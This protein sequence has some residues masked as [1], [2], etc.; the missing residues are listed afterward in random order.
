MVKVNIFCRS[1][2]LSSCVLFWCVSKRHRSICGIKFHLQFCFVCRPLSAWRRA[3]FRCASDAEVEE[4]VKEQKIN[5][6]SNGLDWI[7]SQNIWP[8]FAVAVV[9]SQWCAT[10]AIVCLPLVSFVGAVGFG[11]SA[12]CLGLCCDLAGHPPCLLIC[13]CE[14]VKVG[15]PQITSCRSLRQCFPCSL[16]P[17]H[18]TQWCREWRIMSF[19]CR[20]VPWIMG[21]VQRS[22]ILLSLWTLMFPSCS[23][24]K[25][26]YIYRC[27]CSFRWSSIVTFSQGFSAFYSLRWEL[28]R[29]LQCG[30]NR[31]SQTKWLS[32]PSWLCCCLLPLLCLIWNK[33]NATLWSTCCVGVLLTVCDWFYLISF[34]IGY[35]WSQMDQCGFKLFTQDCP[36]A[37]CYIKKRIHFNI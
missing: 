5:Q 29:F 21:R 8:W 9:L 30:A 37:L 31:L 14:L 23:S 10:V 22:L 15:E 32:V 17:L 16:C 11:G 6:I 12:H 13:P 18:L 7:S 20:L 36:T 27:I 34:L 35:S 28:S 1:H 4:T 24:P 19:Y 3:I 2:K 33:N 26:I 25:A